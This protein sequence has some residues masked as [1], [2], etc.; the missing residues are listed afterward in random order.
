MNTLWLIVT[1]LSLIIWLYLILFWGQFWLADRRITENLVELEIYPRVRA[2]VP[3]RNEASVLPIS[4]PSLLNQDYAG[5]FSTILVDDNSTDDTVKVAC[6]V[7]KKYN[8]IK[9]SK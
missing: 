2:I 8:K 6:E 5:S 7:A 4:L 1:C 9:E 3:A